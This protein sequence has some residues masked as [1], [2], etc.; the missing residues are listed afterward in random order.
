MIQYI[1]SP[2]QVILP[3]TLEKNYLH[4][5]ILPLTPLHYTVAATA[6]VMTRSVALRGSEILSS[7]VPSPR[8]CETMGRFFDV[9]TGYYSVWSCMSVIPSPLPTQ[10]ILSWNNI[11]HGIKYFL[12]NQWLSFSLEPLCYDKDLRSNVM[13]PSISMTRNSVRLMATTPAQ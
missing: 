12:E 9:M 2:I 4:Y 5:R 13:L 6:P 10:Q 11:R 3:F 7:Y 8:N 1:A